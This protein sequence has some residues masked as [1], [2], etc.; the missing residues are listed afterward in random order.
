MNAELQRRRLEARFQ[1][2]V[3]VHDNAIA[4]LRS[5]LEDVELRLHKQEVWKKNIS[6]QVLK[7]AIAK[8]Q[9]QIRLSSAERRAQRIS[10]EL[11][12]AYDDIARLVD[13][14]VAS[15]GRATHNDALVR[16]LDH[17]GRNDRNNEES[18]IHNRAELADLLQVCQRNQETQSKL[19]MIA[20]EAK[21]KQHRTSQIID[22]TKELLEI[23]EQLQKLWIA[24]PASLK[25]L[26]FHK[27]GKRILKNT[28]FRRK[29]SDGNEDYARIDT[30]VQSQ[31]VHPATALHSVQSSVQIIAEHCNGYKNVVEN[32]FSKDQMEL[33]DPWPELTLQ[34]RK[35]A[36]DRGD[37]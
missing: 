18:F 35:H 11:S 2:A 31:H 26:A 21:D 20:E 34:G 22:C 8:T 28:P 7:A 30:D 33:E 25:E 29:S 9:Y 13:E 16:Y 14:R 19:D 24:V 12:R 23:A 6:S 37:D 17:I 10:M 15:E 36:D 27:Q 5:E 1:E 32:A 4:H 3:L